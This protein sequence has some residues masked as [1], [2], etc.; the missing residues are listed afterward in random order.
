MMRTD[1]GHGME[2]CA[3]D[4]LKQRDLRRV[5]MSDWK[6]G[7]LRNRRLYSL[8]AITTQPFSTQLFDEL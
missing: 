4:S 1:K 3:A 5:L 7:A 6:N 2:E 8:K